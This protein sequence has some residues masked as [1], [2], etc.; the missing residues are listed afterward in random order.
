VIGLDLGSTRAKAVRV[1]DG[2]VKDRREVPSPRWRELLD[3]VEEGE[4]IAT[5]GY[6]RH[7]VEGADAITELTAARWG[8]RSIA[9]DA[10]VIVDIGGQDTKVQ[11]LRTNRFVLNDKCSAGTGAFLELVASYFGKG[12]EDL[13]GMAMEAEE[14]ADINSTCAVFA[15]SEMVSQLVGGNSQADV[16][17]GMHR[18]FAR[19]IS[20]LVPE[21]DRIV[22]MG[23]G[24]RNA[25]LVKE[26][27]SLLE[28]DVHV[29]EH[30]A[31][32]NAVGA[33]E[34][35]ESSHRKD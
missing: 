8:V 29:P 25:G 18:A 31:F 23:G 26:L 13:A 4:A 6:F 21:A 9:P 14:P 17:A 30:P 12:I 35:V 19:R 10:Q 34:Y 1:V 5:T 7:H 32:V 11:D 3:M 24:A 16:V 27:S 33:V 28:M 15:M 20:E 2:H 22:L